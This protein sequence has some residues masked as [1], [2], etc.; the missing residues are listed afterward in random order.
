MSDSKKLMQFMKQFHMKHIST[1]LSD[2]SKMMISEIISVMENAVKSW[3]SS[4]PLMDPLMNHP[5]TKTR[6]MNHLMKGESYDD[7]TNEVMEEFE[8]TPKI[9]KHCSFSI[10]SRTF[11]I[12]II[13]PDEKSDNDD[14]LFM[15]M[16]HKMYVWLFVCNHHADSSCS[17]IVSI[18][19]YLTNHEKMLPPPRPPRDDVIN[20]SIIDESNANTGFTMACPHSKNEIY[21][22]RLEEWFKVLIH[23]SFHCFGLDFAKMPQEIVNDKMFSIFHIKCDLRFYET[24][25]EM[26]AEIINVI[27]MSVNSYSSCETKINMNKLMKNIENRLHAEQMFSLFQCAKVLHFNGLT[28]GELLQQSD[29]IQYKERTSMFSYYILK[30]IVMF[31]CDDFIE[32]CYI[33]NNKSL[34]FVKTQNNMNQF[35]EFIEARYNSD[36]YMNSISVFENWF[37]NQK[38]KESRRRDNT[39]MLNTLRMSISE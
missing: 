3:H 26:W 22:Y 39:F 10:G 15:K 2:N 24:Y 21:V 4:I 16:I 27:F 5:S 28:Y 30:S 20:T 23:E 1:K 19:I 32:W 37:S 25:C 35:F 14:E 6:S 8:N 33:H 18:H 7:I 36:E 29:K 9:E 34:E 13:K 11:N 12:H 38:E 31:Y 17:P